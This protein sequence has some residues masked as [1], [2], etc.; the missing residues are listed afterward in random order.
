LNSGPFESF[1]AANRGLNSSALRTMERNLSIVKIPP[2]MADPS[3]G[4]EDGSGA[5]QLDQC[6]EDYEQRKEPSRAAADRPGR[7]R[8]S[9]PSGAPSHYGRYAIRLP[10]WNRR[11]RERA[12]FEIQALWLFTKNTYPVGNGFPCKR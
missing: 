1:S 7:G 11:A 8:V 9:P 3:L 2:L 12:R 6:P 4:E 10:H 5:G